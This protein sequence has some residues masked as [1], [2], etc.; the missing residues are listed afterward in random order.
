M[1]VTALAQGAKAPLSSWS[2]GDAKARIIDFVKAVTTEENADFVDLDNRIAVFDNDGTLWGEQPM[3]V[4]LAF[5]LDRVKALV[6]EHPEWQTTE[7]FK[8]VLSGDLNGV[9]ASGE[10][11]LVELVAATHAG[12]TSE[13]FSKIVAD[14]IAKA[15]H[16]KLDKPYTSLIFQPMLEVIDYLK[17][18]GFKVFIVSGGGIEFMRP[19][20]DKVYGIPAENVIGSSIKTKYEVRDG[21]PV[22]IRLPEI[23]FI[24]D[25]AGKPVGINRF[26]GR[27]PIAAFGNS[28]GDFE[29]L[30]WTTSGSGRRL[31]L[32]VHHDDGE[33][34]YAY[35]RKSHFGRLDRGLDEG[36][37]R[38]W[39][40]ASM[41]TD[42]KSI[43]PE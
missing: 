10:R 29:M 20:T 32:L 33:R 42:W 37:K 14:W 34:E 26:I 17:Q 3:Y 16:P 23:D 6:P 31:G 1:P 27:Q 12:M 24:D 4:Q 39:T 5:V 11:G 36:P 21:K 25:K 35:D 28:D 40:I 15:R 18:N 13:E 19:W 38:G 7:P 2:D 41:K 8:S 22:I 30:E 43:Y 9:A